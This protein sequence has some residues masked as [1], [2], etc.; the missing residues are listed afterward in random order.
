MWLIVDNIIKWKLWD[1]LIPASQLSLSMWGTPWVLGDAHVSSREL[2]LPRPS[3]HFEDA[4]GVAHNVNMI[5]FRSRCLYDS[6]WH[7]WLL[8]SVS[9]YGWTL[10]RYDSFWLVCICVLFVTMPLCLI[11]ISVYKGQWYLARTLS[12]VSCVYR[13]YSLLTLSQ[14]RSYKLDLYLP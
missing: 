14:L 13:D 11:D 9:G 2:A 4:S 8:F 5:L 6:Q 1:Q 12:W 10:T 3:Y 7:S